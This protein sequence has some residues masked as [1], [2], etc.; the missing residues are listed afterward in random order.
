MKP[1]PSWSRTEAA[2]PAEPS[3]MMTKKRPSRPL[4]PSVPLPSKKPLP[5]KPK[6]EVVRGN[7]SSITEIFTAFLKLCKE[8]LLKVMAV[9]LLSVSVSLLLLAALGI[10]GLSLLGMDISQAQQFFFGDGMAK[11]FADWLAK[12]LADPQVALS[13]QLTLLGAGSVILLAVLL[14][15]SWCY[16]A[17]LAAAVDEHQGV[18]ESLCTGWRYLFPMFWISTLFVGIALCWSF[19][20]SLLPIVVAGLA[21]MFSSVL[22]AI[23]LHH[24]GTI[25]GIVIAFSAGLIMLLLWSVVPLSMVFGFIVMIDEDQTNIDALLISRLYVRGNWWD[26]LFKLFLMWL[27]FVAPFMFLPLFISQNQLLPLLVVKFVSMLATPFILL[28]MV[29]VYSDLKKAAGK[30]DPDSSYRCL[31][32][33]MAAAGILLPLLG[34]I[35]AAVTGGPKVFNLGQQQSGTRPA[36]VPTPEVMA[37][38]VRTVPA[39][40]SF[41][42]W[43]DPT[44]D[45]SNPLLDIR[46]VTALGKQ[47]ELV[48]SVTFAKPIAEYFATKNREQYA[49][50]VS[51][52]FDVDRNETT[53]AALPDGAGRDGYD[54]ELNIL[55]ATPPDAPDKG[56]AYPSLYALGPQKRQSLAPLAESATTITDSTLTIRLPYERLDVAAGGRLR[57][58]FREAAQKEGGLSNDQSVPLK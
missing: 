27:I 36:A 48:L 5:V 9:L 10:G 28:Y 42:I 25:T 31:W 57:I 41:V 47:G 23:D 53:G 58:C 12:A 14:F 33:M 3:A 54:F 29:A 55:L 17:M 51:F 44:G 20:V 22:P 6:P 15:W 52:F 13:G 32:R 35:G 4:P 7:V 18:V 45:T 21:P 26:T 43:R 38:K 11:A 1:A 56:R 16:T 50:L 19:I 46:E 39:V 34:I 49:Q 30:V 40:D 8:R 37:P 2:H 24:L